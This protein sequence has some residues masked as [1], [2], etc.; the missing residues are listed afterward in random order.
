MTF[1]T[2]LDKIKREDKKV[3]IFD[4]NEHSATQGGKT[5]NEISETIPLKTNP[6][7]KSGV[8]L[9]LENL[10]PTISKHSDVLPKKHETSVKD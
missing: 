4:T 3:A 1:D 9:S 5:D 7:E 2:L 10:Q 8:E 6:K